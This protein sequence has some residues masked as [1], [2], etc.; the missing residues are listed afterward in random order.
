MSL[1]SYRSQIVN[2]RARIERYTRP[3]PPYTLS[4]VELFEAT[5][6]APPDAWQ[7]Q[8]LTSEYQQIALNCSRQAGKSTGLAVLAVDTMLGRRNALVMVTS[9][10]SR[11]S[12]EL[13]R[14]ITQVH[15]ACDQGARC[16]RR[17]AT[18]IELSN[19]SRAI[20]LPTNAATVRGY[21]KA[22]LVLL[23]EAAYQPDVLY[24]SLRPM[25]A[26][27]G[28]RIVLGSTPFGKRGFFYQEWTEGGSDW[29]RI[30]VPAPQIVRIGA[31]FLA[32]ER[33][34]MGDVWFSQEYLCAFVDNMF[35][36][37]SYESVMAALSDDVVPLEARKETAWMDSSL[38]LT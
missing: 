24:R 13:L 34:S 9:G 15:A 1:Q 38:A 28:G 5:I 4:A 27:S 18:R 30:S 37:F 23:D 2:L 12:T 17:S 31:D 16:T 10:S 19:G 11:Q 21:S 6:G 29:Q 3:R 20:A 33:R 8:L 14:T 25:L 26:V 32:A 36:V 22:A 35:S 7:A